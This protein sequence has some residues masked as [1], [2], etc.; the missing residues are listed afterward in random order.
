MQIYIYGYQSIKTWDNVGQS[1]NF[2]YNV[3]QL[4]EFNLTM[5]EVDGK[6]VWEISAQSSII[7]PFP[8]TND[9]GFVS[10]PSTCKPIV[11]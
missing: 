11:R 1:L 10:F 8:P 4:W 9:R 5:W 3:G 2:V 6:F 7:S